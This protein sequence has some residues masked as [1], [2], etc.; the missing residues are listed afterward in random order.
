MLKLQKMLLVLLC[1][2]VVTAWT[3]PAVGDA[4]SEKRKAQNKLLAYRAARA[5][6]IRKLGERIVGLMITSETSVKDFVT[7][8]DRIET[9]MFAYLSGMKEVGRPQYMEDDTCEVTMEIAVE[10][11]IVT[12]QKLHRQY[13]KGNKVRYEDIEKM[14]VNNDIKIL[15][16]TGAG[17]PRPEFEDRGTFA[18]AAAGGGGGGSIGWSDAAKAYWMAHCTGRGRLMADRAARVD[19]L[20][21]LSERINGMFINS[22]TQVR[23]FVAESDEIETVMTGFIRGAREVGKLYHDNELIVEVEMEV[24]LQELIAT[25]KRAYQKHYKGNRVTIR[26]I[27]QM[28]VRTEEKDISEVGMGVPPERY[29]KDV[30]PGEAMAQAFVAQAKNWPPVIRATGMAAMDG[31]GGQAKLMAFRAAELDG[32]RKL[33]EEIDGL[34]IRSETTVRDFVAENDEIETSMLTYQQGARRVPGSE[35]VM[36]DGTVEVTVEIDTEPLWDM[37]LYYQDRRVK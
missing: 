20:R 16:E 8:S 37:V 14:S 22:S 21:K 28:N 30:G 23:D 29:L 18:P 33:A 26:E 11:I 3:V 10:E 9:A 27:E 1:A 36:E 31:D 7:E 25:L 4:V 12:L 15:R 19:A 5:D 34:L 17:A 6:A 13:Y 2:A 24:T 32:R 35:K